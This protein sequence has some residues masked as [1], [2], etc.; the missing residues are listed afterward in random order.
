MVRRFLS[1]VAA[2]LAG[3]VGACGDGPSTVPGGYRSAAAWSSFV[4]A[5]ADGP[6]LLELRGDPFGSNRAA[7]GKAVADGLAA[8]IPARPFRL[9]TDAS[10]ARHPQFRLVMV[11]GAAPDLDPADI[12]K[13]RVRHAAAPVDGGRLGV[14]AAFC[15][16]ETLLSSVQGWVG[17]VS[18]EGDPRFRQLMGQ[19]ARDLMGGPP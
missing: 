18:D 19:V 10:S 5:T 7:L 15:D 1:V 3:L 9:T 6:L 12:C 2:T 16:G 11:L 17:K 8:G 13:G 4:Y 14:L